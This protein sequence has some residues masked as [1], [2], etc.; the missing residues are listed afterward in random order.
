[1]QLLFCVAS[2]LSFP[3]TLALPSMSMSSNPKYSQAE[4]TERNMAMR[5]EELIE[6]M[7]DVEHCMKSPLSALRKRSETYK[8]RMFL[9]RTIARSSAKRKGH[10]ASLR[11][12][13]LCRFAALAYIH[14]MILDYQNSPSALRRELDQMVEQLRGH[15]VQAGVTSDLIVWL[16]NQP[17]ESL[18]LRD[19]QRSWKLNRFASIAKSLTSSAVSDLVGYLFD[20]L[21]GKTSRS[22]ALHDFW[23]QSHIWDD[24]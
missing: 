3:I 1:M 6:F 16:L 20:A 12:G 18:R 14:M 21:E 17:P 15:R 10:E 22:G 11:F 9:H 8:S 24:A 13:N 5:T 7:R 19:P 2:T 4:K 23:Q